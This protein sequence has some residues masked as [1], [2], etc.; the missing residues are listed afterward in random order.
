MRFLTMLISVT[1][2]F[3]AMLHQENAAMVITTGSK[4]GITNPPFVPSFFF[5]V[6]SP[7]TSSLYFTLFHLTHL[8]P[9]RM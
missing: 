6:G 1:D 2:Y 9:K 3:Q 4:Q 7:L 8:V 5:F